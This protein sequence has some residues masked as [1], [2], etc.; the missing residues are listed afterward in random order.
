MSPIGVC[1]RAVVAL[2]LLAAVVTAGPRWRRWLGVALGC[3]L[4][5]WSLA[6]PGGPLLRGTIAL[7]AAWGLARIVDLARTKQVV[8]PLQRIALAVA[9]IDT[10]QLQ[11]G[12]RPQ[13]LAP[14]FIKAAL[15]LAVASAAMVL[16]LATVGPVRW[17][18]GIAVVYGLAEVAEGLVRGVLGCIGATAPALHRRPGAA[19]SLREFWGERWNLV[20]QRWLRH[21]CFLPLARRRRPAL[22]VA[23]AFLVSAALHAWFIG[24]AL[25]V[26]MAAV[27]GLYFVIQ[28]LL[29]AV[30]QRLGVA[31]WPAWAGRVWMFAAT[32]LPAPLFVEP[33]LRLIAGEDPCRCMLG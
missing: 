25:G 29:L 32:C 2:L 13:V 33:F 3:L 22:G 14:S 1:S 26:G 6:V 19:R 5:P 8:P 24:V 17:V 4:L 11:F 9:V 21:H 20:V 28:G 16:A 18:A 27:M 12:N 23:A 15:W 30:E 7:L 10:R 31:R